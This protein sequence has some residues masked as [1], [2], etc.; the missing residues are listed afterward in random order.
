MPTGRPWRANAIGE[1]QV[2]TLR[3]E[4]TDHIIP[5]NER[6]LRSVLLEYVEYYNATRPH[7]T[8]RRTKGNAPPWPRRRSTSPRWSPPS[9]RTR[10]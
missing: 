7:R 4:C 2:G 6:H 1:R 9:L 3:R 8:A 10:G 5:L